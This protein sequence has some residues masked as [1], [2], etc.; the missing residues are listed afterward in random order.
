MNIQLTSRYFD[1]APELEIYA[2]KKIEHMR[3]EILRAQRAEASCLVEFSQTRG[4]AAKKFSTCGVTLTL[5]DGTELTA[6]ETTWHMY[7]A[8]DIVC[9][10]IEQQL[11]QH[12]ASKKHHLYRRRNTV[13][14]TTK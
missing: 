13:K 6:R 3:K 2:H 12:R 4:N 1:I 10:H 7:A 5:P 11:K 8:F 14:N 9:A